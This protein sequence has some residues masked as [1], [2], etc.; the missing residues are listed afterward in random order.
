MLWRVSGMIA[1]AEI[2]AGRVPPIQWSARC[3][4]AQA[5]QKA[6]TSLV[7]DIID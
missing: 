7:C 2:R 5:V 4:N 6:V 1:C 3:Y